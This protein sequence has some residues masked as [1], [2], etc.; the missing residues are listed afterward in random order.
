MPYDLFVDDS[1]NREYD[2]NRDYETSGK[3]RHFAYGSILLPQASTTRLIARFRQQKI[4]TFKTPDVEIKSN[5]LRH[6]KERLT[7]YLDPFG[8]TNEELN[9]FGESCYTLIGES[10]LVLIGV[11]VDKLHMQ[12]RYPK[13]WYAPTAAYEFLMQRVVQ[14]VPDGEKVIVTVDDIGG[15][16]PKDR[17][18]R[19]LLASHHE[20]LRKV[21]SSLQKDVPFSCI[22]GP[23]RFRLSEQSDGVQLADLVAYCVFRQFKDYPDAWESTASTT[24]TTYPYLRKLARKFRAGADGRIQGYGIVK[25]PMLNRVPWKLKTQEKS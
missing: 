18:Y 3:H 20:R 5:W 4:D 23:V 15:K 13:P 19:Q 24:L 17:E 25:V 9:A 8:I 12:E 6:P 14:A 21:G 11:A 16:T 22:D 1:G 7:R 10:D 2:D